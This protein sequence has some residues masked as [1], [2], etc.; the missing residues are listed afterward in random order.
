MLVSSSMYGQ[1]SNTATMDSTDYKVKGK[2]TVE[3][4][5]D[6]YYAYNF[7]KP[8]TGSQPYFVSMSRHNEININLAF[9]DLKYASS[10]TRARLV[11]GF[12]TYVNANYVRET[13][14]LKNL[15]EANAGIK[16]FKSKGV[17]LDVGVI[18]SP[19]TNESAISRDH[20][21]YTRSLG[22]ENVPYYLSGAKLTLPLS[23]KVNTYFYLLNG[24]QQ[25]GDMNNNKSIGT[26]VE[27][28]PS[29]NVLI[30]WNTFVGREIVLKDSIFGMRYFSDLYLI[31]NKERL[32]VTSCIY[33][34]VQKT[35][36]RNLTW[37]QANVVSK[38][39]LTQS[40]SATIRI[41]Y[42]SDPRGVLVVPVFGNDEFKVIGGSVG[43][44]L[45]FDDNVLFR[46]EAKRLSSRSQVFNDGGKPSS[47]STVVTGSLSTWF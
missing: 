43:L 42:F 39:S 8:P 24:W 14:S 23:K 9:V 4:Y 26:Q 41:E 32:S 7:N 16:I 3:G 44:N 13:G 17:W 11:P 2:V 31:Y 25:I 5:L 36:E 19:Y 22:A 34:G 40:V 46:I 27:F 35:N 1:V 37:W 15:I 20:L 21:A 12:G 10:R 45:K 38:Y 33:Y 28:R 47:G 29:N 6:T 30:N 18:G